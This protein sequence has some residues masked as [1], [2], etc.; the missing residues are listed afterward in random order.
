MAG[1]PELTCSAVLPVLSWCYRYI[2]PGTSKLNPFWLLALAQELTDTC[3][4]L[5][6]IKFIGAMRS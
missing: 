6:S 5:L 4:A 1:F 2:V 3:G